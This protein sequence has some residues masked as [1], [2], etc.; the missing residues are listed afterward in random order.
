M[1]LREPRAP[2]SVSLNEDGSYE[3]LDGNST[4]ANAKAS[5]W[6]TIMAILTQ[7]QYS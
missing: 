5:N 2:I 7:K 6:P 4:Y 1:G 3:V